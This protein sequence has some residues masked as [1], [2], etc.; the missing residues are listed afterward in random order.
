MAIHRSSVTPAQLCQPSRAASSTLR[1]LLSSARPCASSI[2][3]SARG[4]AVPAVPFCMIGLDQNAETRIAT[5][6]PR[7]TAPRTENLLV[8]L[9]GAGVY[10]E[11][12]QIGEQAH[13]A[14]MANNGASSVMRR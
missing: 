4:A 12:S 3:H 9:D 1:P 13:D 5:F 8:S 10:A 14:T 6:L 2:P 7:V 11:P